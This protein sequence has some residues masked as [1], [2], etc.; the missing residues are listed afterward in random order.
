MLATR[1]MPH[2]PRCRR[3]WPITTA[4][5][6]LGAAA[7]ITGLWGLLA[8]EHLAHSS[9]AFVAE[10]RLRLGVSVA[11]GAAMLALAIYLTPR[12]HALPWGEVV[13]GWI[14]V[15]CLSFSGVLVLRL[16]PEAYQ[17]LFTQVLDNPSA[18][19][20]VSLVGVAVGAVLFGA[21]F[22]LWCEQKPASRTPGPRPIIV[23]HAHH[24]RPI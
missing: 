21:A 6:M 15:G 9:R 2:P 1:I 13:E 24:P 17:A 16:S 4:L 18:L 11:L 22:A 3:G 10:P 19:S 14:L 5:A 20:A 23:H 8:P 12:M 7:V